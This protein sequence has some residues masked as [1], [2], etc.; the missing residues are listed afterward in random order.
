MKI[1]SINGTTN[2]TA[3]Y[4]R[5]L[6]QPVKKVFVV[7]MPGFT[8]ELNDYGITTVGLPKDT[9]N[10][11]ELADMDLDPEVNAV[12]VGMDNSFNYTKLA[13]ACLFLRYNEGCKFVATNLDTGRMQGIK[14]TRFM[15]GTGCLVSAVQVG[16]GRAPDVVIGKPSE[17]WINHII[18]SHKLDRKRT[19]MFGDRLDT[20]MLFAQL[21]GIDSVLVLTGVTQDLNEITPSIT[22][23]YVAN[24]LAD[25]A[26]I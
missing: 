21:G 10:L 15:A 8:Q 2:A 6:P 3:E 16:C 25:F 13:T 9:N 7:G 11:E 1:E 19:V 5:E 12:V 20:D 22:P 4:L 18:D 17:W 14:G 23:T 26:G 24:G